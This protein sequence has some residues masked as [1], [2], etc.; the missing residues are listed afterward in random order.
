MYFDIFG[1]K[2]TLKQL[3]LESLMV[4]TVGKTLKKFISNLFITHPLDYEY[5]F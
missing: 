1:Y 5:N 4:Y 3:L 2:L